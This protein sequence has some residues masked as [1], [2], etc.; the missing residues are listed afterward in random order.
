MVSRDGLLTIAHRSGMF[1]GMQTEFGYDKGGLLIYAETTIWNKSM[2]NPIKCRCFLR[3]Y[4]TG[5]NLWRTKPHVMIQKCS[6][7]TALRRA[8]N[9]SGVYIPEEMDEAKAPEVILNQNQIPVTASADSLPVPT[10]SYVAPEKQRG[11]PE[12]AML[13]IDKAQT[14]G[15]LAHYKRVIIEERSWTKDELDWLLERIDKKIAEFKNR[16]L[17]ET[18]K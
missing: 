4:S 7:A 1:D 6:E 8:F 13:Q 9:V 3:E 14:E 10:P 12:Q 15:E 16:L 5:Q 11:N 17:V 2:K 18:F